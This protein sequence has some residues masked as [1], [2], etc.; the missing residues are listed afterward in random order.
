MIGVSKKSM[1]FHTLH[2]STYYI[3]KLDNYKR[4][5][6]KSWFIYRYEISFLVNVTREVPYKYAVVLFGYIMPFLLIITIIANTLIVIVLAQNHM[7]TPTNLVLLAMAIADL[8]TLLFPAPWYFY[9][10]T[11]GN[12]NK[13]LYPPSACYAYHCMIEVIPAFF[14]TASIWL[15]LLLAGQR[16]LSL[17]SHPKY[18]H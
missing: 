12:H 10:Y 8:L 2:N 17:L 16:Y 7:R 6:V 18:N 15:T 11:F 13:I 5:A 4:T 14:H 3:D 1:L 9:M